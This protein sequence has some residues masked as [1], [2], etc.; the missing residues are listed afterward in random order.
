VN[1]EQSRDFNSLLLECIQETI[2]ALLSQQVTESIFAHLKATHN[3]SKEDVPNS[4]NLLTSTLEM[5]FGS[6]AKIVGK[7]I[8]KRLY[9]RLGLEFSNDHR[10]TLVDYVEQAKMARRSS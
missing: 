10:R 7:A 3:I 2:T 6:S 1:H 8:A 5:T 9:A 4:L